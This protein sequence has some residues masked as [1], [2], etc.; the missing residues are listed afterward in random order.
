MEKVVMTKLGFKYT[1]NIDN[2]SRKGC[3]SRLC[4][5]HRTEM[6]KNWNKCA[7]KIH[8]KQC[9][10][11]RPSN[12]ITTANRF[13]KRKEGKFYFGNHINMGGNIPTEEDKLKNEIQKLQDKLVCHLLYVVMYISYHSLI[14]Y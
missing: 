4:V 11:T 13:H 1:Q 3:F 9:H 10:V 5:K 14:I 12:L 2:S 7:A 8:G 6:V